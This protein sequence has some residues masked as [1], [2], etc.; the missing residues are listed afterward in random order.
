VGHYDGNALVAETTGFMSGAVPGG[1]VRSPQTRL[2]E[3][4][5][6]SSDGGRL[7]ITYTWDDPKIYQKPHEYRYYFE[8]APKIESKAG[9]FS[10][11]LEEWCDAGDPIEQQS[12]VPPKQIIK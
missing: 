8:R 3:R 11:A 7:T 6:M 9:K 5:E 1:G 4:F 10:Y 12:I 2:V